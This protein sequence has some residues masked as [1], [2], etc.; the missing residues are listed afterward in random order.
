M[1]RINW[2]LNLMVKLNEIIEKSLKW[3]DKGHNLEDIVRVFIFFSPTFIVAVSCSL[4][5]T[6]CSS[7]RKIIDLDNNQQK[8]SSEYYVLNLLT[9]I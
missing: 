3:D 4:L 8:S 9:N 6:S 2:P 1:C 5:L 7:E